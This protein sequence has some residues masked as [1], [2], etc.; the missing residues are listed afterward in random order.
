MTRSGIRCPSCGS[1]WAVRNGK[2]KRGAQLWKCRDCGRQFVRDPQ[3]RISPRVRDL[4]ALCLLRGATPTEIA[5][6]ARVSRSWVYSIRREGALA[7]N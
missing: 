5:E 7:D 3:G 6:A 2:T 1:G 4:V